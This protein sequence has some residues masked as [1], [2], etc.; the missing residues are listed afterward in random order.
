[1]GKYTVHLVGESNYQRAVAGLTAGQPVKL[2]PEPGNPHDPRAIKCVTRDNVTIGYVE[3]DSWLTRVM[4]DEGT[5]VAS[6][7]LEIIGG[8]PGQTM[9]GVV[10]DV[11]TAADAEAALAGSAVPPAPGAGKQPM[12][13][14][15]KVLWAVGV[16]AVIG[17]LG[18]ASDPTPP[19]PAVDAP[20]V[21]AAVLDVTA[22]ELRAAYEANE[23]AAQQRF[24]GQTLRVSGTI[25]EIGLDITDDPMIVF[26]SG[27]RFS[28]TQ[29]G[30]TKADA[31]AIAGLS[32]GEALTVLCERVSEVAGTPILSRC[33]LVR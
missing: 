28:Q 11:R 29:A 30:F 21:A 10:L 3:R 4:I 24:G 27:D 7:V 31:D 12:T 9:R 23:V 14:R 8:G 26:E 6:R 32:K 13:T 33:T 16:I 2:V 17:I 20:E 15:A 25:A 5:L 22:G 18:Q 1:M 19:G